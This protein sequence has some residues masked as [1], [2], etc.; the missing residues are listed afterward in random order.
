MLMISVAYKRGILTIN[1]SLGGRLPLYPLPALL[2]DLALLP[3]LHGSQH[4]KARNRAVTIC[5]GRIQ[6]FVLTHISELGDL[7]HKSQIFHHI[8]YHQ[9]QNKDALKATY[10]IATTQL[11]RLQANLRTEQILTK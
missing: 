8:S 6:R 1:H 5:G 10:N 11:S 9:G 2:S 3:L 7:F 4:I